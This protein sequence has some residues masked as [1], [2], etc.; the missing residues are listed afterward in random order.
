RLSYVLL[1]LIGKHDRIRTAPIVAR[2]G[3]VVV[4]DPRRSESAR[5]ASEHISIRP[6]SDAAWLLA[7]AHGAVRGEARRVRALERVRRSTQARA[8]QACRAFTPERV[9]AFT[10]IAPET[11]RRIAR[12]FAQADRAACY[13]RIGTTCQRFGSLASYA[14]DLVNIL[15]GNLDREGGAMFARPAAL[16]GNNRR[17]DAVGGP[18]LRFGTRKS[19]VKQLPYMFGEFPVATF[20]R[21]N[22]DCG[23]RANPARC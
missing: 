9:A 14:V 18:G 13:G 20:G 15:T 21:W 6:G 3:R 1:R 10:G 5:K 4:V 8:E 11:T 2:G 12:E 17:E 19:R 23:R 16:R 22:P 7:I